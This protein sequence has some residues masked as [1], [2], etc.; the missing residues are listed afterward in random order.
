MYIHTV[1]IMKARLVNATKLRDN[2]SGVLDATNKD[3]PVQ[4]ISRRGKQEHAIVN[5][6]KLE[7]LL[8]ASDP[9]YLE[10]IAQARRQA[11]SGDVFALEDVFG[12]L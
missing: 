4:I 7:D 5:L 9:E 6:D 3:N 11:S 8:A 10:E 2:L 1:D 12:D